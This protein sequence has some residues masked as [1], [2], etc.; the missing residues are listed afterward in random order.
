MPKNFPKKVDNLI[1]GAGITGLSLAHFLKKFNQD[2]IIVES[3]ERIG[4]NINTVSKKGFI[5][6]NGPNTLL[7]DNESIKTL[8]EDFNISKNIIFPNKNAKNRFLIQNHKLTPIPKD[9]I[10]FVKSNILSIQAKIRIIFEPFIKKHIKDTNV[11]EFIVK[12][13][14]KEF[15][16]NLIEPFLNGIY[17]GDTKKMSVKYVLKKVWRMEQSNGSILKSLFLNKTN[18]QPKS[19]N[20]KNGLFDLLG[21]FK[22]ELNKKIYLKKKVISLRRKNNLNFVKINNEI[23]VECKNIISTI[24]A[25]C[26]KDIIFDIKISKHLEKVKYNPINVLHFSL[27]RNKIY[28]PINGFGVLAKPADNLSFLGIL[29]NSRIFPHLSPKNNDLITVMVGGAKQK[30]ILK[31]PKKEIEERVVTDIKKIIDFEGKIE[32]L[33]HFSWKKGIPQYDMNF[34]NF[35]KSIKTFVQKNDGLFIIGNFLEGVS[36]SNCVKAGHNTAQ[37]IS[38]KI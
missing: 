29:F 15:H 28:S 7:L 16:D 19:F 6:E 12:R 35:S 25:H 3:S 27:E 26:L 23:E 8:I 21:C 4:G 18:Y 24:P 32:L 5:L 9:L 2:F 30:N 38:K 20:F 34:F 36:V 10:G 22:K 37:L 17:A 33:N 13:F 11:F 14:G 31:K 1:I